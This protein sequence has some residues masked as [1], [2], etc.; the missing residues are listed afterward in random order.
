MAFCC[1]GTGATSGVTSKNVNQ[2]R[3]LKEMGIA[4]SPGPRLRR[5]E[6]QI[7]ITLNV[8]SLLES[9][10]K[11]SKMGMGV[12]HTGVV[13]YGIEWGYGEVVEN[14]NASGLF[15]V[16]PG[17]A[18]GTLYRT[19]RIG[20]TTRSPM[21]VDTILHRL[22]NEWRS[23]EYHIL[24]HNCNHFAQAFCD[25]LSTTEKLQVP[26]WCNRAARVGDR[27]IPRR[28]ATKV[29]HMMDDEPPKAVAPSPCCNINEVP[30]SVVPREW[31][32][33]PSIFQPLRYIGDS[34]S[35]SVLSRDHV[36]ATVTGSH[37]GKGDGSHYAVEYD[38]LPP[39]GYSPA[40]EG[41]TYPPLMHREVY[42][43]TDEN[44]S[45]SH[46]TAIEEQPSVTRTSRRESTRK[47]TRSHHATK[48][49]DGH[50]PSPPSLGGVAAKGGQDRVTALPHVRS[51]VSHAQSG[52]P[53]G[54]PQASVH[55]TET[56][57]V[58]P[59]DN[60]DEFPPVNVP[61]PEVSPTTTDAAASE[62]EIPAGNE[63]SKHGSKR[64]SR[65]GRGDVFAEKPLYSMRETSVHSTAPGTPV[66]S[67]GAGHAEQKRPFFVHP[68][69]AQPVGCISA[70]PSA[71]TAA[72]AAET[73]GTRAR[74]DKKRHSVSTSDAPPTTAAAATSSEASVNTSETVDPSQHKHEKDSK[75]QRRKEVVDALHRGSTKRPDDFSDIVTAAPPT[76]STGSPNIPV[77]AADTKK[78]PALALL[79]KAR[80]VGSANEGTKKGKKYLSTPPRSAA[81]AHADGD[82]NNSDAVS[83]PALFLA[84]LANSSA[85]SQEPPASPQQQQQQDHKGPHAVA[86][87]MVVTE[88]VLGNGPGEDQPER[89]TTMVYK[90]ASPL[91]PATGHPVPGA[92]NIKKSAFAIPVVG[93]DGEDA[94]LNTNGIP[95]PHPTPQESH[96]SSDGPLHAPA[97]GR[98]SPRANAPNTPRSRHLLSNA[99]SLSDMHLQPFPRRLS[100]SAVPPS[101]VSV[102][103]LRSPCAVSLPDVLPQLPDAPEPLHHPAWQGQAFSPTPER[104]FVSATSRVATTCSSP[105]TAHRQTH[106]GSTSVLSET[107]TPSPQSQQQ[108]AERSRTPIPSSGRNFAR[109]GAHASVNLLLDLGGG[110]A[111]EPPVSRSSMV[112][113]SSQV[114][115]NVVPRRSTSRRDADTPRSPD[116]IAHT[117]MAPFPRRPSLLSRERS[118][119]A[120]VKAV[121]LTPDHSSSSIHAAQRNLAV[122]LKET[123]SKTL[124]P[125]GSKG[126]VDEG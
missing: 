77:A 43:A 109:A 23:S 76:L 122:E 91:S 25:L 65:L 12:Y 17:Q 110:D 114:F 28:L 46:M 52:G 44:G 5:T 47:S 83:A 4:R 102:E 79:L 100:E 117:P 54:S 82:K 9:N 121:H 85:P 93:H 8:Y 116:R 13:V 64:N 84:A 41:N 40:E 19:I 56:E 35:V 72:A 51:S 69:Q 66:I 104:A 21:Q 95:P 67:Y 57:S 124:T 63:A 3:H 22:E 50:S 107:F 108:Q 20:Y 90:P 125:A 42:L 6:V 75:A 115:S 81:A 112:S 89:E 118:S 80:G 73:A 58:L 38:I 34:R 55:D 39:P 62:D 103:E 11:L 53:T 18:A 92:A 24:H 33:H 30:L 26:A 119:A 16:H 1:C 48:T 78:N 59:S 15:C 7:P 111:M 87:T 49:T 31:Y 60:S 70:R 61:R 120:S 94:L 27:I 96:S 37:N 106:R 99:S 101:S 88:S 68:R 126:T 98:R 71:P 2:L 32:L 74:G 97:E 86:K 123:P 113:N 36:P 14:P 29:Q 45:V 105:A 10:A